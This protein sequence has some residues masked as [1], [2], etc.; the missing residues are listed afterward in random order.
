MRDPVSPASVMNAVAKGFGDPGPPCPRVK[1]RLYGLLTS[2]SDKDR[3]LLEEE[4][5]R[6]QQ[7]CRD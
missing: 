5:R 3:K 6:Y 4:L 2:T 1:A 7:F